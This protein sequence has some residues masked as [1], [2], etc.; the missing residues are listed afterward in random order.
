MDLMTA[1]LPHCCQMV[2][3][4]QLK[5]YVKYALVLNL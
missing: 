2:Q 4:G 3:M 1:E 5:S